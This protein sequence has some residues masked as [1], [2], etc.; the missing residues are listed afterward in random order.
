MHRIKKEKADCIERLGEAV[1]EAE[2]ASKE[3]FRR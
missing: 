1:Q 2:A 3:A